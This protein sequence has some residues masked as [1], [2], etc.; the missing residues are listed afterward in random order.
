MI[1]AV[2]LGFNGIRARD[3]LDTGAMLYQLNY[4][5]T[6]EIIYIWSVVVCESD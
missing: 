2:N 1:I 3:L 6:H 5:A 4:E